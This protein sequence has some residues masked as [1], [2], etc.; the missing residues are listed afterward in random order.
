M[1]WSKYMKIYVMNRI[2]TFLSISQ[3]QLEELHIYYATK[4]CKKK[5]L[6]LEEQAS[7]LM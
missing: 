3:F 7:P 4:N 1:K 2:R 6:L 5:N